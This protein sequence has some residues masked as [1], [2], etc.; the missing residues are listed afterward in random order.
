MADAS[1]IDNEF[2]DTY[3]ER[4]YTAY[5]DPVAILRAENQTLIPWVLD[6]IR[7]LGAPGHNLL[8]VACGGGF[9]T[10]DFARRRFT[11]TGVDLSKESLKT[12]SAHDVTHSARYV[13]GNAYSLPFPDE[14]FDIV[15]NMDF[16][17]HVD[18]PARVIREC[19][20][21]LKK[22][23]LFFFHTFNRNKVSEFVVIRLVEK[24][25]KNT[26]KNMHV[27]ELFIPP[28]DTVRFCGE[29]GMSVLELTGVRPVVSSIG[30]KTLFTGVVSPKFR[31]KLTSS[32]KISYMGVAR[33]IGL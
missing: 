6:R 27:P 19:S 22:N 11:V 15:T 18:D 33:K 2:Y 25:I 7:S 24:F 9:L 3:G 32:L 4:W 13:Y 16:L 21:V 10:N 5:D 12:A 1:H 23:G 17:E 28:E 26:P 14:S 8:D 31:F 30:V 29:A 20:R